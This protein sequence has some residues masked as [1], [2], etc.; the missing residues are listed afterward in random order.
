MVRAPVDLK[1]L[2]SFADGPEAVPGLAAYF[3]T[4]LT[5]G[6]VPRYTGGR[7][8]GWRAARSS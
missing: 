1:Q 2:L 5:P 8:E 7:F 6:C 4:D 3:G